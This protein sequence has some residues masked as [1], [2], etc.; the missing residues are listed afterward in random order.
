MRSFLAPPS[1]GSVLSLLVMVFLGL[2]GACG[3]KQATAGAGGGGD[4]AAGDGGAVV[5][6]PIPESCD[7]PKAAAAAA[8]EAGKPA[9][10]VALADCE[11]LRWGAMELGRGDA[12]EA[13]EAKLAEIAALYAE[14]GT[15]AAAGKAGGPGVTVKY[16]I[17][18]AIRT[19]DLYRAAMGRT[20][21]VGAAGKAPEYKLKARAA[22]ENGLVTAASTDEEMRLDIDI[23]DWVKAGCAGLRTVGGQE[24][25]F[26]VCNPWRESWR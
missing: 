16:V 6:V 24:R 26:K 10:L 22:Y 9:A 12:R 8:H 17:G 18:A 14:A 11:H 5:R 19:G 25:R 15:L 13:F 2:G 23:S 20:T 7:D 3:G 21:K 4:G 1:V